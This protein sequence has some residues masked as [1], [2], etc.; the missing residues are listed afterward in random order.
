MAGKPVD[1]I[2]TMIGK[3]LRT[4]PPQIKSSSIASGRS[5]SWDRREQSKD[6]I[7]IPVTSMVCQL[8]L[9]LVKTNSSHIPKVMRLLRHPCKFCISQ[10]GKNRP[11]QM[12]HACDY[13]CSM[14]K[15][16]SLTPIPVGGSSPK[17]TFRSFCEALFHNT[18]NTSCQLCQI[19]FVS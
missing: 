14:L 19:K 11:K 5:S 7:S 1:T 16:T 12:M 13:A 15:E 9:R 4:K 10:M 3:R 6:L 18:R 8:R 2:L 17:G